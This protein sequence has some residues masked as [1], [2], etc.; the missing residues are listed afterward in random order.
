MLQCFRVVFA[1]IA[2]ASVWLSCAAASITIYKD[3]YPGVKIKVVEVQGPNIT[4]LGGSIPAFHNVRISADTQKSIILK[5][6][7]FTNI[8]NMDDRSMG[9]Q[10]VAGL[11]LERI[12]NG[13]IEVMLAPDNSAESF[14]WK[15]VVEYRYKSRTY[16]EVFKVRSSRVKIEKPRFRK[17]DG[18]DALSVSLGLGASSDSVNS[19]SGDM[20]G[21][22]ESELNLGGS[23]QGSTNVQKH[24]M[25]IALHGVEEHV[26]QM[27]AIRKHKHML[28]RKNRKL[29]TTAKAINNDLRHVASLHQAQDERA[30][31]QAI[32][33][34]EAKNKGGFQWGKLS[35]LAAGAAIGGL[36]NLDA[37]SQMDV[38]S[39]IVR[40]SR[41]GVDGVSST[42]A[43]VDRMSADKENDISVYKKKIKESRREL[44]SKSLEDDSYEAGVAR[45][46]IYKQMSPQE[47]YRYAQLDSTQQEQ[48]IESRM[49]NKSTQSAPVSST[50]KSQLA[51]VSKNGG[52]K[53]PARVIG[54]HQQ[55]ST[56]QSTVSSKSLTGVKPKYPAG[57]K[58]EF[59]NFGRTVFMGKSVGRNTS[60]E[61]SK[62][63]ARRDAGTQAAKYCKSFMKHT[64][65]QWK[66]GECKEY[67]SFENVWSCFV[68]VEATCKPERCDDDYCGTKDDL[69]ADAWYIDRLSSDSRF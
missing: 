2:S 1:L 12:K 23:R 69:R 9:S 66:T 11:H 14:Q 18:L 63:E 22:L 62:N 58:E 48:F 17:D 53:Q 47:R 49:N 20:F 4:D 64:S 21:G 51:V 30:R 65:L 56:D 46:R 37:S 35:A 36:G 28:S 33:R 41:S 19:S 38:I 43:T 60:I 59:K 52:H 13:A 61:M 15:A 32:A 45:S 42:R 39:S 5:K 6:L 55:T 3:S 40:D 31:Q 67:A 26:D 44:S 57:Y 27:R 10:G 54:S 16:Q 7:S 29:L 25:D 68:Y 50:Y 34:A 24:D 8:R